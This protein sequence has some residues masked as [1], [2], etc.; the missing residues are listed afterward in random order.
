MSKTIKPQRL[1]QWQANCEIEVTS[2]RA[3]VQRLTA[4]I[5]ELRSLWSFLETKYVEQQGST[6]HL[7]SVLTSHGVLMKKLETDL[8]RY[9]ASSRDN[10]NNI[11][12]AHDRI[13][14]LD[15]AHARIIR[16]IDEVERENKKLT[17][18]VKKKRKPKK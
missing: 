11:A 16:Y 12:R 2:L 1:E 10:F 5:K 8:E 15:V 14:S 6:R 4:E 3:E 17:K 9:V 18:T 13:A 7:N